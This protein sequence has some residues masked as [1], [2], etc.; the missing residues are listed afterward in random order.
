VHLAWWRDEKP[1]VTD[2]IVGLLSRL[3]RLD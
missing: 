1:D 2:N 3:Y